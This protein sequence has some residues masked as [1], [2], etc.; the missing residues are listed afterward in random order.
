MNLL[1]LFIL[2][3]PSLV[4]TILGKAMERDY[5][6]KMIDHEL[7]K[8]LSSKASIVHVSSAAPSWSDFDAPIPGTIINVYEE[9]DVVETV[10]HLILKNW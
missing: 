2:S 7:G 5:Y 4:A 8:L 10:I 6:P 3:L 1:I 9:R